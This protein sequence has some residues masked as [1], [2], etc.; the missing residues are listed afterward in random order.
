MQDKCHLS[1]GS[2]KEIRE[3]VAEKARDPIQ[4]KKLPAAEDGGGEWAIPFGPSA[5]SAPLQDERY[6]A[7]AHRGPQL[8]HDLYDLFRG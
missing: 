1:P 3:R 4:V 7:G 5:D 2:Q 8:I 6:R